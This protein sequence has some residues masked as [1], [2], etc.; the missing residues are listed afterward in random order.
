MIDAAPVI[1]IGIIDADRRM[2]ETHLAWAR[3]GDG[4][5]KAKAKKSAKTLS[6]YYYTIW[7]A[8][9][10]NWDVR[11]VRPG[12]ESD[13]TIDAKISNKILTKKIMERSRME[14]MEI[15]RMACPAYTDEIW[16]K[17]GK[18][19]TVAIML[20]GTAGHIINALCKRP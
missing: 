18:K 15:A 9:S 1:G 14:Q 13:V 4:K 3:A 5:T 16:G 17:I 19:Q 11:K 6:N 8:P 12:K 10:P 2:P 20:S 7:Q